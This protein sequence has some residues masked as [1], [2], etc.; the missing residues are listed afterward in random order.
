MQH[1][2]D[3]SYA[4]I[5]LGSDLLKDDGKALTLCAQTENPK[6]AV[7]VGDSMS[8][9]ACQDVAGLFIG[10]GGI[11]ERACVKERARYFQTDENLME[12]LK[13]IEK[14]HA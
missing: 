4:G 3:G 10:Y 6:R 2:K 7:H 13:I 5:S 11:V 8:D 12:L 9:L 1:N 14:R